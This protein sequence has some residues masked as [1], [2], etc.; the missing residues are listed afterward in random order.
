MLLQNVI[1]GTPEW[2]ALRLQYRT[3]SEAAAMLGLSKHQSRTDL[4]N[5]KA[6]GKRPDVSPQQQALFD[7]GHEAEALARPLAEQILGAELYPCTG[8]SDDMRLLASFD[9]L[10]MLG[11]TCWEHK[12]WNASL[13]EALRL[14]AIPAAHWPQLEQQLYVSGA[15]RVLFMVSDGTTDNM[16]YVYYE[17][18]LKRLERLLIGW[19]HFDADLESFSVRKAEVVPIGRSPDE[20]PMLLVQVEGKV[21]TSNLPGFRQRAV[22]VIE[23]IPTDLD[24]DE[25]FA[26]AEK[27]TKWLKGVEDQLLA[28]KQN[29]IKQT[30]DIDKLFQAIDDI[31]QQA[32]GKRLALGKQVKRRKEDIKTA[33]ANRAH[34]SFERCLDELS[35]TL[36]YALPPIALDIDAALKGKR[37]VTSLQNAADTA[38]AARRIDA[39]VIATRIRQ[40]TTAIAQYLNDYPLLFADAATL[41]L[42]DPQTIETLLEARVSQQKAQ[43]AEDLKRALA[44]KERQAIVP[45]PEPK[46]ESK[47]APTPEP[48]PE[49]TPEPPV[50]VERGPVLSNFNSD[51]DIILSVSQ[52]G[53]CKPSIHIDDTALY[54]SKKL[55]S[56]QLALE[57]ALVFLKDSGLKQA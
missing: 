36:A 40:N 39:E 18:Q 54:S 56:P 34:V 21:T 30:A 43:Q 10:D 11:D 27:T 15:R 26:N 38:V 32:R 4:L 28:A 9:G 53:T 7:K 23:N 8:L 29:A 37:T 22:E 46:P 31:S 49:P 51:F 6:T 20:L 5:I 48:R 47:P 25:D 55:A 42:G 14:G 2:N 50:L 17:S 35:D 16:E 13:A 12:L 57:A 41:V 44:E 45:E 33:I 19:D 24:T 3:A 52:D 1:Q